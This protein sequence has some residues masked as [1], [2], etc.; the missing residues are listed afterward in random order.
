M[1]RDE[2]LMRWVRQEPATP[3]VQYLR[4]AE[5]ASALDLLGDA[6][7]VLDVASESNVTRSLPGETVVRVDFST[8]AAAYA[9]DLL[10]EDLDDGVVVDP[11]SPSLPFADDAFDGA[12]S[13]GPFDWKFLDLDALL[14]EV[15]RVV[16]EDGRFAF[17]VPTPRSPYALDRRNRS[18][19]PADVDR[20]LSPDWSIA[21]Y[22]LLFQ[23][24]RLVHAAVNALPADLQ[25]PFVD[26]QR[27]LSD[28]LSTTD[29]LE[30]A[31]YLVYVVQ[32]L[33]YE[34]SLS[35][36]L[37][38][39]F[40]PVE[41]T[42]FFDAAD[43]TFVRAWDYDLGAD[44]PTWTLDES[45]EWRYAPFA[46]MGAMQWRHST[47]G[48]DAFDDRLRRTLSYFQRAVG[49][50][51]T[52]ARMPTYG[53]GP[54]LVAFALA[55]E[56]FDDD[57]LLDVAW[58]L[59]EHTVER[60]AFEHSEDALVLYGWTYLY[61][62][63]NDEDVLK[64]VRDGLWAVNERLTDQG[65]FA[66]DNPTTRRHQNQMYALWGLCR[67]A[68]VTGSDGFLESAERVLEH[69]IGERMREDGAFVWEDVPVTDRL[70]VAGAR[71]LGV[72]SDRPPYWE[73]LYACHQTFFVNAVEHYYA[74]GGPENYD[75]AVREAMAWIY[76]NDL[77]ELSGLGVPMRFV[78]TDGGM[79]TP[80]QEYKGAYE[81]GSYVMALSNLLAGHVSGNPGGDGRTRDRRT[82]TL[83]SPR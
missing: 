9:A 26:V 32:P 21:G 74:A 31:A 60:T 2:V 56:V 43:G 3:N 40:R 52:L 35:D 19:E 58:T 81:I 54:L 25:K 72:A 79:R 55:G 77:V 62:V 67:G 5:R 36:A 51:E 10:G 34:R 38:C 80:D 59:F 70:R 46:L 23:Y 63:V 29:A 17:S 68:E 11:E 30:R 76:R 48:T 33:K 24:P 61:E 8:D 83:D 57:G 4:D 22:D 12:V 44:G 78:T 41:E 15:H 66:F 47:L 7:T 18:F 53:T 45:D 71:R 13:I 16:S 39:L 6:S 50:E 65:L 73:F 37:E 27:T 42:G 69:T 75:V 1:Q 14:A 28:V 20:L 49:R 64:A 82:P